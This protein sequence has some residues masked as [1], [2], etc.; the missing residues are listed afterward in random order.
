MAKVDPRPL[1]PTDSSPSVPDGTDS[2]RIMG[3]DTESYACQDCG[4]IRN[5][6]GPYFPKQIYVDCPECDET[7]WFDR[8]STHTR[9]PKGYYD[10]DA[11]PNV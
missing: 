11:G 10:P 1:P 7:R 4:S 9:P 6:P 2:G 8:E 5:K 3:D